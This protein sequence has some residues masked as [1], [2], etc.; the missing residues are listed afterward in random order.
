MKNRWVSL[1][2]ILIVLFAIV[3]FGNALG[4]FMEIKSDISYFNRSYGL[5]AMNDHFENGEY[6]DLYELTLK[7]KYSKE[8]IEI[9]TS[10]YEAF[11]RYYYACIMAQMHPED[12]V[13]LEKMQKEKDQIH[14]KKI[15]YL[16]DEM[17][18]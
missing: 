14:W 5:S 18:K 2:R 12:P 8:E 15:L 10:E 17:E 16:I 4:A 11:G 9:D 13:Y 1:A 7:N 3:L 6:Y